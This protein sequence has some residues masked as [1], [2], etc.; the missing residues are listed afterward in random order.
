MN[1]RRIQLVAGS[2]YSVSLP[3]EWIKK[4]NLSQKDELVLYERNDRT[5]LVSP[6]VLKGKEL[7]ETSLDA[8]E[9][10]KSID[11]ILFA[12][13]YLGVETINLF[14]KDGLSKETKAMVRKT[15]THMSGTMV[16]YEDP[17]K[18]TIRVLLDKSKVDINQLVYR[19]NLI[20]DLS[21]SNMLEEFNIEEIR[22]NENEIDNIYHLIAKIISLSLIDSNILHSSKIR[23]VILVP[24]YF[25]IGKRLEHIGDEIK[26]LCEYL[27]EN[28]LN[29]G[30]MGGILEFKKQELGRAISYFLNPV[31]HFD[32]MDPEK[33]AGI[34]ME[35]NKF[36]DTIIRGHLDS[37]VRYIDD[38][39]EEIVNISFYN[40]LMSE[41][42]L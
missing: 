7:N 21:I 6:D 32:K 11:Q 16:T 18:M 33:K 42:V 41:K 22:I 40:K 13:Y 30:G 25:R 15:L 39:E 38:I 5:L 9:Y 29:A 14:S 20:I 12:V 31:R 24:P 34:N 8:D 19:I 27:Y 35:L 4:N 36:E 37:V 23:H 28:G 17:K 1:K 2:T 26:H 3:K 10:A